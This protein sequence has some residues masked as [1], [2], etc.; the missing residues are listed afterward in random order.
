MPRIEID[1]ESEGF[2]PG[3]SVPNGSRTLVTNWDDL[4]WAAVTVGRPNRQY[5]FQHGMSSMYEA[6]FRWSLVRMALEQSGP[7]AYRLRRTTA[8][9]TLDPSEKGA[10]NYFLGLAICKLFADKVLQAPWLMHLDVFRPQLNA[11]L[12]GRSRPDLVGEF[13]TGGWLVLE[14]KGRLSAPSTEA[15]N[16]AKDQAGRVTSINGTQPL[17]RVGGIAYFR[18]DVLR[19]YWQD[20]PPDSARLK[21]IEIYVEDP[22]W[23]YYYQPLLD[24]IHSQPDFYKR[25][26]IEPILMPVDGLDIQIGILPRVLHLLEEANWRAARHFARESI[27]EPG[28]A[29]YHAD[30][31]KVVSGPTWL[32]PFEGEQVG[33]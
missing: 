27:E 28:N 14:C 17:L 18:S 2:P 7:N 3:S 20:P 31:I 16:K 8:A 10:V 30:G 6:L 1:Y 32:R 29:G 33:L 12:T 21:Q 13:S 19:F 24:L 9:R 4:L 22:D 5:V 26:L 23:R 15:K 11:V 25:M